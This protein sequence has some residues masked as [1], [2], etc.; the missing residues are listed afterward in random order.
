MSFYCILAVRPAIDLQIQSCCHFSNRTI[1][2]K[3]RVGLKLSRVSSRANEPTI[4][5]EPGISHEFY[6]K[7]LGFSHE[8]GTENPFRSRY[9]N[10]K[11]ML[12]ESSDLVPELR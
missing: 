12:V 11:A 5:P 7:T 9:P 8:I 3:K 2:P 4:N 6:K 10:R 1:F